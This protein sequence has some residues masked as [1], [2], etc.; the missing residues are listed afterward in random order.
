MTSANIPIAWRHSC[1]RFWVVVCVLC[2]IFALLIARAATLPMYQYNFWLSKQQNQQNQVI[3]LPARRGMLLDRHGEPLA[4]STPIATLWGQP[5]QLSAS[6]QLDELAQVLDMSAPQLQKK[7]ARSANSQFFYLYRHAGQDRTR[8]AL[9]LNIDGVNQLQEYRRYYPMGAA[10]AHLIGFTNID[11]R[12]QEGVE[13]AYNRALSGLDGENLVISDRRNR[14]IELIEILQPMEQG[15]D[16]HLS[17]DARLQYIL[18]RELQQ[19]LIAEQ[20]QAASA[21]VMNVRTGEVLAMDNVPSY[22]PNHRTSRAGRHLRNLSVTDVL[23]PGS[24]AKPLVAIAALESGTYL[25]ETAVDT[26]PGYYQMGDYTIRDGDDTRIVNY[27]QLSLAEVIH[28]SSNVG[29]S[30]VALSLD[31]NTLWSVFDRFGLGHV[32]GSNFPGES[33]GVLRQPERWSQV[34]QA[35]IAFGYGVSATP[36]QLV[37]AYSAIAADGILQKVRFKRVN[38]PKSAIGERVIS[39]AVAQQMRTMLEGVTQVGTG[40]HAQVAHYRVAGKTGTSRKYIDGEYVKDKHTALFVGFAPASRPVLSAIV[41]VH[42]PS[43]GR[44]YGGQ[45]AAPVFSRVMSEALR[46]F[47]VA[48]DAVPQVGAS[49]SVIEGGT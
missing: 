46:L 40:R 21:I 47:N 42:E 16:I 20:A 35:V 24:T 39:A 4:I 3:S 12:G 33:R 45:V 15:Q 7:L 13:L 1:W 38:N 41:V 9:S 43:R 22:N 25:P 5:K 14:P 48:P 36:L 6:G 32:T 2:A 28:Q 31:R 8:R 19:V 18:H 37:R 34:D 27:G 23:E 44:V 26:A 30:R 10:A 29:I 49:A 11:D 17:I